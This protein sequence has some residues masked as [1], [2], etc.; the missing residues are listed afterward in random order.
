MMEEEPPGDSVDSIFGGFLKWGFSP[1][2]HPW[3]TRVFHYKPYPFWGKHPY[4]WK[5]PYLPL[6]RMAQKFDGGF[7][8]FEITLSSDPTYLVFVESIYSYI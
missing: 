5:H 4:F 7:L 6:L 2:N 1:P 8:H 3:I